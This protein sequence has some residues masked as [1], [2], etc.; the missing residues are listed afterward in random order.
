MITCINRKNFLKLYKITGVFKMKKRSL[1]TVFLLFAA[2]TIA[3]PASAFMLGW[4][5]DSSGGSNSIV[6]VDEY[7]NLVG[8]ANIVNEYTGFTFT[9]TGTFRVQTVDDPSD[10]TNDIDPNLYADF[11]GSGSL[12]PTAFTF[13]EVPSSLII[14]NDALK[15]NKIAEFNL[16][17]GGG[18]LDPIGSFGP[19]P[20]GMIEANF[21]AK[22]FAPGYWF[23]DAT[24]VTSDL[25]LW[26]LDASSP[27][28]TLGFA[29]TN[30]SIVNSPAPT[31]DAY[32]RLIDF[33]V[34]NNGQ[35]RLDVVP[36]PGTMILFGIGLLGVAGIGRRRKVKA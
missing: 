26:T 3:T 9:E 4:G 36:E 6:T 25:S 11:T 24:D 5:L 10:P 16:L 2:I 33:T 27:I 28:L 23:A 29:T 12:T 35:F 13:D 32:G 7:L 19:A 14:Y 31:F 15:I 8:R 22:Y 17:S 34:S 30:A 1:M 20:N 18:I 21:I